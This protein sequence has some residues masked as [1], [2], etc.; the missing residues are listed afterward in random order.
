MPFRAKKAKVG[1]N[2]ANYVFVM[3]ASQTGS[4]LDHDLENVKF[5]H[6]FIVLVRKNDD[7]C[8][9]SS[10]FS[11]RDCEAMHHLIQ[12]FHTPKCR[13]EQALYNDT[14]CKAFARAVT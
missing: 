13:S 5:R 7:F 9:F 12:V 2:N 6:F 14:K 8:L 10:P 3:V 11:A 4:V 1:R